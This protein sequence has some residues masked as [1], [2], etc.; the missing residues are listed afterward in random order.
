M[1]LR[2]G[3]GAEEVLPKEFNVRTRYLEYG[4]LSFLVQGG[5]C[6]FINFSDQEIYVAEA[7]R[8]PRRLTNEKT[9]R[10]ADM[11]LDRKRGRLLACREVPG[12]P[13]SR[14]SICA[15]D[16]ET[17]R[18][19]DLITG[20]DFY[21]GARLRG[22]DLLWTS[23]NHP[24]MPWNGTELWVAHV[25]RLDQARKLVGDREHAI[26]Q[27]RWGREGEIFFAGELDNFIRLYRLDKSG[28]RPVFSQEAE[29]VRPDWVPGSNQYAVLSD[30]TVCA[31]YL[32]HGYARLI[33][34]GRGV[35]TSAF[36]SVASIHAYRDE[37]V[38]VVG[39]TT[40]GSA[41][42]RLTALGEV[43]EL[44]SPKATEI[45]AESISIAEEIQ[46]PTPE[47]GVGYAWFY[48]PKSADFVGPQGEKPPAVVFAHG[49]PTAMSPAQFSKAKQFWTSRGY[50]V[51]DVNYGGS[52]GYGRAYR[53]RLR[54]QWGIVDVNDCVAAVKLL[55]SRGWIDEKRVAIRGGSAGG[56]TTL[57]A[58]AFTSGIFTAG[59][60]YYGVSDLELLAK[61]T[62]K[63]ESRYLDQLVGPYPAEIQVYKERSPAFQVERLNCPIIFFQGDE[64]KVVPPNQSEIMHEALK[65]KGIP[66]EYQLYKKEGHGFRRSENIQHSLKAEHAFYARFFNFAVQPEDR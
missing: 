55:A 37:A 4:A 31:T 27:P 49:G 53:E 18:V 14:N 47:G 1:R 57:A 17:G 30:G 22:D 33:R 41:I 48:A 45:S 42:V 5:V 2:P 61:E 15:I 26:A 32:E 23:W 51:V 43:I 50:A 64:D 6:Y 29:F 28:L 39:Q 3:A 54:N 20:A 58:L 7:G 60:S 25:D 59:A 13:E 56:Y 24:N 40:R 62:H 46:F 11:S 34:E 12:E 16:L 10:F 36:A 65:R 66:T 19:S 38:A 52:C 8:A 44:Y 35:L 63:L 9:N 21:N